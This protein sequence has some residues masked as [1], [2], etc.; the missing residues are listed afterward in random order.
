[1]VRGIRA[2]RRRTEPPVTA[3][4]RVGTI[5]DYAR[6]YARCADA[7]IGLIHDPGQ[8]W[9]AADLAGWYPKLSDLTPDSLWFRD[10]PPL[11]ELAAR[12]G[13]PMFLKGMRQTRGH[14]RSLSIVRNPDDFDAALRA[15][16]RDPILC[17]QEI[18]VRRF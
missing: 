6:Y 4:A 18:V 9:R 7:R 5:G 2:G 13:W 12:F 8:H 17:S 1:A 15:Y 14:T 11:D 10:P 3:I 16:A